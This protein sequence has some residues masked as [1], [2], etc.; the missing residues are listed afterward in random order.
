M[1]ASRVQTDFTNEL[2]HTQNPIYTR[3]QG[4]AV[5]IKNKICLV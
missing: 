3:C 5:N 4:T 2:V 1:A